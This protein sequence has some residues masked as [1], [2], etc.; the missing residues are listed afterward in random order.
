M[1][2][3]T[4]KKKGCENKFLQGFIGLFENWDKS[5]QKKWDKGAGGLA[6]YILSMKE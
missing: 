3:S 6:L 5:P 2:K 4:P 1:K